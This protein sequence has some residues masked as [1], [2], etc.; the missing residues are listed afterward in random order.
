VIQSIETTEQDLARALKALPKDS[1]RAY[2]SLH[3]NFVGEK[4]PLSN[5]VRSN[6]YPLGPGSDIGG[7][8]ALISRINH[9]CKPNAKHSWNATLGKQT[10]YAI[11]PIVAGQEFS[12]SYLQGGTFAERQH[13]LRSAFR[14]TC[15][16][17]LCSLPA[18]ERAESDARIERARS[19]TDA[20]G[21]WKA[22]RS[23]PKRVLADGR[24]LLRVYR[25]EDIVPG[26]DRLANVYWDLFQ[27][28][29]MHGDAARARAFA[30]EYAALKRVGEGPLS[31]AVK[32]GE[33]C[34]RDPKK[35]N[36]VFE[37]TKNWASN[38]DDVPK[39]LWREEFE[40]WMFREEA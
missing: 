37:E 35:G 19:L 36:A 32:E 23:N 25:E 27:V 1:Q 17:E 11:R 26:D 24:E 29:G 18:S 30:E 4:S 10:V 38:V 22:C 12:L 31:A 7:V 40:R 28:S 2:L 13:E 39:R 5:I 14:F 8:F 15:S 34:A 6:G 20:M 9:S 16:C 3:N 33:E 21:D